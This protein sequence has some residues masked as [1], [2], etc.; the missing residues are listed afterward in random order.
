MGPWSAKLS[1]GEGGAPDLRALS[2]RRS[3]RKQASGNPGC[4][5][6]RFRFFLN[7][8]NSFYE[9]HAWRKLNSALLNPTC[10]FG[11]RMALRLRAMQ[12]VIGDGAPRDL[13]P[14]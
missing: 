13:S 2:P 10:K 11:H 3:H 8:L 7:K 4:E 14:A 5:Q 12:R 6:S 1:R 9:L